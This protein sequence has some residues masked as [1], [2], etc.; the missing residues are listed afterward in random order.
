MV[1]KAYDP[2]DYDNIGK[3][4]LDALLLQAPAALPPLEKFDG[5][6]VYALYYTGDFELYRGIS[7]PALEVPIYVGC[8]VP[9]GGRKGADFAA[10]SEIGTV[11]HRR[12]S[13]HSGSI[14][15]AENLSIEDF[16]C[17]YIVVLPV[18]VRLAESLLISRYKPIWNV[19]L[20]GFGNH[21]PGK[22][23][24]AMA[25]PAWDILHPGRRWARRL[26]AKQTSE[27]VIARIRA[28]M[29]EP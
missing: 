14:E 6:G 23:R 17:R 4:I 20:D 3:S 1:S 29:Q 18:W 2:L 8:A 22:G 21:P 28:R 11:L 27:E 10:P 9:P 16:K 15:D 13:E 7:S 25:R 19:Y 12:L 26:K 5:A 24:K